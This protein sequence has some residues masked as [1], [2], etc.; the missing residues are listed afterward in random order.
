M[1]RLDSASSNAARRDWG[2][3]DE[4]IVGD[5][6]TRMEVFWFGILLLDGLMADSGMTK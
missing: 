1:W 2:S 5:G 3:S 6:R 4:A